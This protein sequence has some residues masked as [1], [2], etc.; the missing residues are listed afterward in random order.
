MV[1]SNFFHYR[2]RMGLAV[3]MKDGLPRRLWQYN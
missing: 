3:G 2:E 1:I